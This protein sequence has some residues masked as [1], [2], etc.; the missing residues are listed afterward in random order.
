VQ[1]AL[2][3][4]AS[5]DKGLYNWTNKAETAG[6]WVALIKT[7]ASR[8]VQDVEL[9]DSIIVLLLMSFVVFLLYGVHWN[10][11]GKEGFAGW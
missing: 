11:T 6:L 5:L 2:K 3:V 4:S 8:T 9:R 7:F 1:T 10:W